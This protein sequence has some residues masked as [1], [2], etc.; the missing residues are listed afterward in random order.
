MKPHTIQA[1]YADQVLIASS[2]HGWK[3]IFGEASPDGKGED[4]S[5]HTAVFLPLHAIDALRNLIDD[6]A[7]KQK[8]ATQ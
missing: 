2:K 5:S 1:T 7:K 3:F 8:Q 4:M 6:I